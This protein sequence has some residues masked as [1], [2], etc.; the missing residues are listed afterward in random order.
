[1]YQIILTQKEFTKNPNT[2]TTYIFKDEFTE[3]ISEEQ[4]RNI[5]NA[6]TLRFFKRLGGTESKVYGYTCKGYQVTQLTSTNP[7]KTTKIVRKFKFI[8]NN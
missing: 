3:T 8:Y 7:D 2:K 4:H 1:M 6:D 5:T